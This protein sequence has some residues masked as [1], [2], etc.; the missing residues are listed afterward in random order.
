MICIGFS[1]SLAARA[2]NVAMIAAPENVKPP[3]EVTFA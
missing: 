3:A 2:F 1:R